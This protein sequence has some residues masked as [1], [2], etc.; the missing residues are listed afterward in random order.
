[1]KRPIRHWILLIFI[2]FNLVSSPLY[3]GE[4]SWRSIGL[5]AGLNDDRNDENFEQ[6]EGFTTWAL[7][8]YWQLG[9][10]WALG[11]FLEANAGLLTADGETAFIGSAGPGIF[12]LYKEMVGISMGINPTVISK[13]HFGDENLGGPINFTSHIGLN[14]IFHRHFS[15]G[16]RLQHMSNGVLY[17]H[18]PG[19]NM[20]MIEMEYRF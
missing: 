15:L 7:P 10:G 20:H 11:T 6:Y 1:M 4:M 5:R 9:T 12:I 8:W 16:Y 2:L 17:D 3:A 13:H 18:N 14:I 19:L